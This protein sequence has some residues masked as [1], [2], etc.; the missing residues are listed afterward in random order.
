MNG[1]ADM[2]LKIARKY[3]VKIK[4]SGRNL[5]VAG[6]R[7]VLF[8]SAQNPVI[9]SLDSDVEARNKDWFIPLLETAQA[10]GVGIVGTAGWIIHPNWRLSPLPSNLTAQVDVLSGYCHVF[11]R[12]LLEKVKLDQQ[13]NFGGAEDDDLCMSARSAGLNN[14][15]CGNIPLTHVFSGSWNTQNY[16]QHRAKFRQKWEGK[17]VLEFEKQAPSEEQWLS[18]TAP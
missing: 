9:V 16:N 5:G 6:G 10:P 18:I 17:G 13:F 4:L 3:P 12:E 15:Q 8:Q 2:L 14:W 1:T 11:K 7:E